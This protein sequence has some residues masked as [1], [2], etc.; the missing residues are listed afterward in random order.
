MIN[1][2]H[3]VFDQLSFFSCAVI[4]AAEA[5]L[6]AVDG[7]CCKHGLNQLDMNKGPDRRDGL[8]C[9]HP[10]GIPQALAPINDKLGHT[11]F[12]DPYSGYSCVLSS[13]PGTFDWYYKNG[14]VARALSV[15]RVEVAAW[16]EQL[17]ENKSGRLRELLCSHASMRQHSVLMTMLN[18]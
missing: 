5:A 1:S 11:M 9:C 15:V 6:T 13:E 12:V 18:Q 7:Q 10:K 2:P 4:G 14:R 17:M 8:F 3:G 16:I